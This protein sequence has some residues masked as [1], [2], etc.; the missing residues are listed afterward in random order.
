MCAVES[1]LC[2]VYLGG[3]SLGNLRKK[4]DIQD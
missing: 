1:V 4:Y 2:Y 3:A